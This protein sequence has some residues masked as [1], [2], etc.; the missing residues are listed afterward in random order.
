M[1]ALHIGRYTRS[2]NRHDIGEKASLRAPGV[3][4]LIMQEV[5]HELTHGKKKPVKCHFT[6]AWTVRNGKISPAAGDWFLA[7]KSMHKSP[8][9]IRIDAHMWLLP[10]K[11]PDRLR[12]KMSLE[13]ADSAVSGV[14]PSQPGR[15][16]AKYRRKGVD[17]FWQA[18]WDGTDSPDKMVLRVHSD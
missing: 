10:T 6:E 3:T 5:K 4:G 11:D 14:L 13:D 12:R 8:G 7:P 16:P 18:E 15:V 9:K 17:R 1:N 2:V